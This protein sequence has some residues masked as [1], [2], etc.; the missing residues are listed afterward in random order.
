MTSARMVSQMGVKDS[1]YTVWCEEL[2]GVETGQEESS[3]K[4]LRRKRGK[5]MEREIQSYPEECVCMC[6]C[7]CVC[8]FG[9]GHVYNLKQTMKR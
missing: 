8:V 2:S 3:L 5:E 4:K 6:V 1:T 7:V 9:W